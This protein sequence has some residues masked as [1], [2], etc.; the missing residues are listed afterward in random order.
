P[1][2]VVVA[3]QVQHAVIAVPALQHVHH[4]RNVRLGGALQERQQVGDDLECVVARAADQQVLG[5]AVGAA[6]EHVVALFTQDPVLA[7]ATD[8][9]VIAGAAQ[10]DV[11]AYHVGAGGE[12]LDGRGFVVDPDGQVV[13]GRHAARRRN[14]EQV[15]AGRHAA[16]VDAAALLAGKIEHGSGN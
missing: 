7:G 2:V 8:Q 1:L 4:G 10:H 16:D 13:L 15:A 11:T 5:Q 14:L 12:F 6:G 3:P 9:H